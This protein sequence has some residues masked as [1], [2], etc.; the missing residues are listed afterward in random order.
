MLQI[1]DIY[2]QGQFA[3]HSKCLR[4]IAVKLTAYLDVLINCYSH[5]IF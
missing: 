5:K 2:L 4:L 1:V 3:C